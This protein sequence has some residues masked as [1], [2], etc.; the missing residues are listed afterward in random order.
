MSYAREGACIEAGAH[1]R[2]RCSDGHRPHGRDRRGCFTRWSRVRLGRGDAALI[3]AEGAVAGAGLGAERDV[4]GERCGAHEDAGATQAI[5]ERGAVAL[6]PCVRAQSGEHACGGVRARFQR[7]LPEGGV[8]AVLREA[9]VACARIAGSPGPRSAM[10][11]PALCRHLPAKGAM[12]H[13]HP[14]QF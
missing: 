11:V 1:R 3:A 6:L 5:Q 7:A 12:R 10:D 13:L 2:R 14:H 9:R 4:G 8:R